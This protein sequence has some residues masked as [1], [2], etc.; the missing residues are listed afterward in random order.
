MMKLNTW[1]LVVGLIWPLSSGAVV[2]PAEATNAPANDPFIG[3]QWALYPS[4]QMLISD[5]DDIHPVEMTADPTFSI[6]WKRF[7]SM[8]KRDVIVAVIDSGSDS[9]LPE[10]KAALMQ[11]VDFLARNARESK[12][13]DDDTGHGTHMGSIMAAKGDNHEG[14]TGLSN[15]IKILPLKVYD[16]SEGMREREPIDQRIAKAV[17]HAMENNVDV[18]NLSMGWPRV[19]N[20]AAAEEA[21]QKAIQAGVVI[22]VGAGNDHHEAQIFPCA[23]QGVICVGSINM[24]GKLSDYSNYGGHVDMVAPGQGILG[25]WPSKMP[26]KTFGPK[27][28]EIKSGTSQATPMVAATAAILRG[29]YPDEPAARIRQRILQSARHW[30]PQINAGLLDMTGAVELSQIDYVT[31][32]FKGVEMAV[33]NPVTKEF[34]LP[35]LIETSAPRSLD[36]MVRAVS[37]GVSFSD[38]LADSKASASG[39]RSYTV[40]GRVTDLN[41]DH[42]LSYE[43]QIGQQKFGHK[44]LLVSDLTKTKFATIPNVEGKLSVFD[45]RGAKVIQ[46]WAFTEREK[47]GLLLKL[48]RYDGQQWNEREANL[49]QMDKSFNGGIGL[50]MSDWD[51]NGEDDYLFVGMKLKDAANENGQRD[52][53][54][55]HVF[56]FDRDL[57]LQREF[58]IAGDSALPAYRNP[59]DIFMGKYTTKT[60]EAFKVPVFWSDDEPIPD[61]DV[62]PDRFAFETNTRQRRLFYME[63]RQDDKG[64]FYM[65]ARALAAY[66]LD[67]FMRETLNLYPED[68]ITLIGLKVQSQEDLK[69]GRLKLMMFVGRGV[70]GTH[71]QLNIDDLSLPFKKENLLVINTGGLLL[72]GSA[73]EEGW[74]LNGAEIDRI[75]DMQSFYSLISGRSLLEE[76]LYFRKQPL[77]LALNGE[78][79]LGT[80]KNFVRGQ[81]QLSLLETTDYIRMQG[82]WSGKAVNSKVGIL[83]SNFLPG[84]LFS[85]ILLPVVVGSKQLP[86]L[87]MD[88]SQ[89]FSRSVSIYGLDEK[90]ELRA[91]IRLSYQIPDGCSAG[92]APF[93]NDRGSSRIVFRCQAGGMKDQMLVVD[94][95]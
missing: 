7:D 67:R 69:V 62:N 27:G 44:I 18:I 63:P 79:V 95:E 55:I 75:T 37:D 51:M 71:Y 45:P 47:E 35:L 84:K 1:L 3:Y 12:F 94:P 22:V 8:M 31:P 76:G 17:L 11:G 78:K 68:D 65:T 19:A 10:M 74:Q 90:G 4:T 21:F 82:R 89:F 86:G 15:R 57:K 41:V 85:Q 77:A 58:P 30:Y 9:S 26:S 48:W 20:T 34:T 38:V 87:M 2:L 40:R 32:V 56:Y 13:T 24:N 70:N 91:P 59:R 36:V 33:V 43:V 73:I 92:R 28:Y 5:L 42:R 66:R 29:I 50:T 88:N 46:F 72:K 25:L 16:K 54:S 60:G 61:L 49:P 53:E 39:F 83:R 14:M 64:A 81:D 52:I 93:W 23:Y 80:L 6:R